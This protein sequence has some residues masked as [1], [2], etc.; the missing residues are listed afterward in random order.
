MDCCPQRLHHRK[1]FWLISTFPLRFSLGG[2]FCSQITSKNSKFRYHFQLFLLYNVK[3]E[4][5]VLPQR[6]VIL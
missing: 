2:N 3:K 1:P 6:E 4:K 5:A